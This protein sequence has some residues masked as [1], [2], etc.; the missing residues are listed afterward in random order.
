MDW[1]KNLTIAINILIYYS[2]PKCA[3]TFEFTPAF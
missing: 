2:M 1:I 3:A